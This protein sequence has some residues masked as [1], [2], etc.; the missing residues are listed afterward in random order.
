MATPHV[1]GVVALYLHQ[2]GHQSPS[3]VRNALVAAGTAGK[4]TGAGTGS[5][6]VLLYSLFDA[7][8]SPT[9]TPTPTPTRTPTP[10]P[11]VGTPVSTPTPTPTPTLGPTPTPT[12]PPTGS[13]RLVNGGFDSGSVTPWVKSSLGAYYNFGVG[14]PQSGAGYVTMGY[15]TSATGTLYQQVTI[16]AGTAPALTFYLNVTSDE[17]PGTAYDFLF[18]EVRNTSGSLLATLASFSNLHEVPTAGAYSL[19]GPYSLGGF[20]GQTVR[21]QFRAVGDFSLRTW[22]RTDTVSVK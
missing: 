13:E 19:R 5:P 6:N 8:P 10:T 17:G 4:V 16:P 7:A 14:F 11:T 1:A 22:F 15:D 20:A 18:V 2:N 21:V 12:A 9:A 3:T